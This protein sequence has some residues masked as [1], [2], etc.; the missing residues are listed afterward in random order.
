M[1][2]D[3]AATVADAGEQFGEMPGW[4]AMIFGITGGF[5]VPVLSPDGERKLD[6]PAGRHAPNGDQ[7]SQA[8]RAILMRLATSSEEDAALAADIVER[9]WNTLN[10]MASDQPFTD[11][12]TVKN[13]RAIGTV[14]ATD[15]MPVEDP[16]IWANIIS[17]RDLLAFAFAIPSGDDEATPAV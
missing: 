17:K 3:I 14:A 2:E 6:V 12:M 4:R 8:D 11:L 7:A 9:R 5:T 13:S 15:F 10:T 16:S 1:C